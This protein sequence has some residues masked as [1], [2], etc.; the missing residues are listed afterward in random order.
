MGLNSWST[1]SIRTAVMAAPSIRL[2]QHAPQAVA[3]GGA[4]AALKRLRG[5]LAETV[6]EGFGVGD[7]SFWFLKALEHKL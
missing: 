6:R 7:E 1:L 5:K 2:Q 3:D 4:E